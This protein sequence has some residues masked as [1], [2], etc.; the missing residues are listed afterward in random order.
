MFRKCNSINIFLVVIAVLQMW[1]CAVV[2]VSCLSLEIVF[3][4]IEIE[5]EVLTKRT[6]KKMSLSHSCRILQHYFKSTCEHTQNT[7]LR[8]ITVIAV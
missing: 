8:K 4:K 2:Q 6:Y 1:K 5:D 3:H 7:L